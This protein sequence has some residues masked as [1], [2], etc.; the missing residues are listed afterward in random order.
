MKIHPALSNGIVQKILQAIIYSNKVKTWSFSHQIKIWALL[1]SWWKRHILLQNRTLLFKNTQLHPYR[2]TEHCSREA[3]PQII[4][5]F[6]KEPLIK[7]LPTQNN[8]LFKIISKQIL[9]K[10]ILSLVYRKKNPCWCFLRLKQSLSNSLISGFLELHDPWQSEV[11]SKKQ[12]V[13]KAQW[14]YIKLQTT[15]AKQSC[16]PAAEIEEPWKVFAVC[17]YCYRRT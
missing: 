4:F 8:L 1:N 12:S 13:E 14:N 5:F 11:D 9:S 2:C 10:H 3:E 6:F 16:S 7:Y 17:L 15:S